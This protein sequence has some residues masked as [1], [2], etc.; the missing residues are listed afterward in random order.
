MILFYISMI[1]RL[2]EQVGAV[3]LY[4][5]DYISF[6]QCNNSKGM[7]TVMGPSIS[8]TVCECR[9]QGSTTTKD[10]KISTNN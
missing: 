1:A 2:N 6:I 4:G 8:M 5:F 9:D 3:K 10:H 7:H